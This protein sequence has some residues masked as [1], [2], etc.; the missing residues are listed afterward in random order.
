MY[1]C[2]V[3]HPEEPTVSMPPG[4]VRALARDAFK[5]EDIVANTR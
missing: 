2:P 3:I 1:D 4:H 5:H